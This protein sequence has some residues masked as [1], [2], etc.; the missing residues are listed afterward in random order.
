[1]TSQV[2]PPKP[3]PT[4]SVSDTVN[5]TSSATFIAAPAAAVW[6]ALI[7]TSTWPTWNVFC[8]RVTI[9]EQPGEEGSDGQSLSPVLQ[10]GTRLTF[11]VRMDPTS[12]KCTDVA[13]VIMEFEP[14]TKSDDG[15]NNNNE[16]TTSSSG[17]IVWGIDPMAKGA[18]PG[19]LLKAERVHTLSEVE[20]EG[21]RGTEV[22]NW[23]AQA[24]YLAYL[25]RWKYGDQL[26]IVF[27]KWV[28][29]LK[30]YV[31]ASSSSTY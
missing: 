15:N 12:D 6:D 22:Q 13:L 31:E 21:R 27:R 24:G 7:D 2:L 28:E 18:M 1:M 4:I 20:V 19:F 5:Y 30:K 16:P 8:P 11:H 23:E 3:T 17:R 10:N 29:G 25:V 26:V 14:P 9:H